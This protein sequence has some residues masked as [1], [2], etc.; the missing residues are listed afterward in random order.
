M[1]KLKIQFIIAVSQQQNLFMKFLSQHPQHSFL[2]LTA[3]LL[4]MMAAHHVNGTATL[5]EAECL[6][7]LM[8]S[9]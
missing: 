4:K 7:S 9:I 2:S 1:Y 3:V 8:P 6:G 5:T